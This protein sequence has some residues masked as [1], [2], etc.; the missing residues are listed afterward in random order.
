MSR[1]YKKYAL[2][3][4]L[5]CILV[6]ATGCTAT[7]FTDPAGT[8]GVYLPIARGVFGK[9]G[10]W[11][12]L[13]YPMAWLMHFISTIVG[14]N[15]AITI[16]IATILIRS[17]A[18]PIYARSNDMSLKM[19]MLRPELDKIEQKYANKTDKE[20]QQRKS[21]ETMALYKK[22]KVSFTSCLMPLVQMP[23][24]LAF[25]ETLRRIPYSTTEYL[26]QF[27]DAPY[28]F[29]KTKNGT[30]VVFT[31]LFYGFTDLKTKIFGIDL[32]QGRTGGWGSWQ[33]W[34]II[35]LAV[36]VAGTQLGIQIWSQYRAKKAQQEVEKDVPEY[37]RA[38][39][40]P[41]QKQS[42]N[43]MKIMMYM[44]PL[45]MVLFVFHSTAALGWY[46]LVGNVYTA[47]QTIIGNK[48][49]EKRMLKLQAK[50]AQEEKNYFTR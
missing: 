1:N 8:E 7:T 24:F 17:A 36:L 18:W 29:I 39:G 4:L 3:L 37:R 49:S 9:G 10:M 45:M 46:W 22:Y 13:V 12:W 27:G 26:S 11:D 25:Y 38:Q 19:R 15:Y 21:M 47:I 14:N 40:N 33:T 31:E 5:V 34:G 16:L 42:E 41:Q 35:I 6:F 30:E 44:M 32:L 48:R 23:I 28:T 50:Y 20:S 2:F 43:M